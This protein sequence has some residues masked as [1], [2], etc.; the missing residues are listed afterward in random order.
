MV[1]L[2]EEGK[3]VER[4]PNTVKLIS[5]GKGRNMPQGDLHVDVST[6]MTDDFDYRLTGLD[7]YVQNSLFK[8][9]HRFIRM[10]AFTIL[11]MGIESGVVVV[12]NCAAGMRR[13]VAAVELLAKRFAEI[14][15]DIR[16]IVQHRGLE[17]SWPV[18]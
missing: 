11:D 6:F 12:V 13:S 15:P 16:V 18:F 5:C 7:P 9:H 3:R 1:L 14:R 2:V 4:A 8:Y 17:A 10:L